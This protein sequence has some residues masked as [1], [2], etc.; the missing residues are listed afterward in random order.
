[1]CAYLKLDILLLCDIFETF[2]NITL[3]EDKLDPV[4]FISLPHMS[5]TTAL[6]STKNDLPHLITDPAMYNFFERGIRGGM[7][8]TNIHRARARIPELNNNKTGCRH[9][10][11]IDA[12]N[13]YGSSLCKPL[14][15][16]TFHG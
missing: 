3:L 1:M 6:M 16:P 2:R 9:L 11:Y 7:T 10:A 14:L 4:H 15:I 8:F 12:N 5:Y 13:L